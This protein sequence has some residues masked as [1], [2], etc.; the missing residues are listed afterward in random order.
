[1]NLI[2][3]E[4]LGFVGEEK[5]ISKTHHTV[6]CAYSEGSQRCRALSKQHKTDGA[7]RKKWQREWAPKRERELNNIQQKKTRGG[8]NVELFADGQTMLS[9]AASNLNVPRELPV[10]RVVGRSSLI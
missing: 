7:R 8:F 2:Q 6:V 9:R 4:K 10:V 1:M 5:K 3:R